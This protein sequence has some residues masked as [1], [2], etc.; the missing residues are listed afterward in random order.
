MTRK[1]PFL[2]NPVSGWSRDLPGPHEAPHV[3]PDPACLAITPTY[4]SEVYLELS[5]STF[6]I[7]GVSTW[8]GLFVL[9]NFIYL[10][11]EILSSIIALGPGIRGSTYVTGIGL[12]AFALWTGA[13]LLR[14]DVALPRDEPVRFNRLRRK[15]YFYHYKRDWLRPFSRQ[16]WGVEVQACDWDDLHAEACQAY[17]AMGTGGFTESVKLS[18]RKAG[19][20]EIVKRFHFS[21]GILRGEQSWAIAQTFMQH[22]PQALPE[23]THLPRDRNNEQSHFNIFWRFAPKVE[24]PADMDLESR[25]AP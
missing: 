21:H 8:L 2:N 12:S 11:I 20:R 15:V 6:Q 7:R 22:G 4:I 10:V 5:T 19:T 1:H 13:Y 24:W 16:A 3:R 18:I 17:G 14:M 23:F 25:T 9:A